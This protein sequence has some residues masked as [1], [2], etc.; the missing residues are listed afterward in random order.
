GDEIDVGAETGEDDDERDR[1]FQAAHQPLRRHQEALP[2]PKMQP[3]VISSDNQKMLVSWVAVSV[4]RRSSASFGRIEI[5]LS[6]CDSQPI[7][8]MN[9]SRLPWIPRPEFASKSE[10]PITATRGS[11]FGASGASPGF[12]AADATGAV[13]AAAIEIGPF[14]SP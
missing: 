11:G 12:G 8:F 10:S 3:G 6:C 1:R 4:I 5:R 9:R 2:A 7:V 14:L 13:T